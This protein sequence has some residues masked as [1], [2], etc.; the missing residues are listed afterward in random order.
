ME[1]PSWWSRWRKY[2]LSCAGHILQGSITGLLMLTELWLFGAMWAIFFIAY[3]GL[4][5]AR[6]VSQE[7]RGDTAGLDSVDF[8]VGALITLAVVLVIGRLL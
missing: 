3:Q 5:F 4:S 1:H 7:G 6:K 8:L 2:P